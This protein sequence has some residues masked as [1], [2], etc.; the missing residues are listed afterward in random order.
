[1]HPRTV[2]MYATSTYL[3]NLSPGCVVMNSVL[4][5]EFEDAGLDI[6]EHGESMH[7]LH[8]KLEPI[9]EGL[10]AIKGDPLQ[11]VAV[12]SSTDPESEARWASAPKQ[13][14]NGD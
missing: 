4:A 14:L 12:V 2:R 9:P 6:S 11:H 10:P 13:P 7:I 5:D 8:G 3:L 1:M